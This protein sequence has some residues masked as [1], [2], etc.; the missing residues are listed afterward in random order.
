M[1]RF[2]EGLTTL[3]LVVGPV[4][5][6]HAQHGVSS[7]THGRLALAADTTVR[8]G[9]NAALPPH[10]STLLGLT[11]EAECPVTQSMART[12]K[13]VQGLD[14]SVGNKNDVVLFVVDEGANN[15]DLYLTS[16]EG[17]LRKVV[18]VKAGVGYVLRV[19]DRDRKA[20]HKEKE[21]WI[22]RLAPSNR[23]K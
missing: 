1:C 6:G 22:E 12:G 17:T 13:I 20:F 4:A 3:M 2:A 7:H 8:E 11:Q 9:A 5:V 21:F 15:Q 16:P 14:V 10:I 23:P 18:S 19:T